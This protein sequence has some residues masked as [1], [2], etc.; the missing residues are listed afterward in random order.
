M[1]FD[2]ARVRSD[3]PLLQQS[4]RGKPLVYLDS[5]ATT[6]KPNSVILAVEQYYREQNANVHRGVYELSERATDAYEAARENVARFIHAS[7]PEE[8]VFVR[9]TTEALN[10]VASGLG[11]V[12]LEKGDTV[13]TTIAEHHSNIVPWHMLRESSGILVEFVDI[14]PAG[15]LRW[16]E[17]DRLLGEGTKVVTV[18]HVSNVLGTVHPVREIAERAHTAGAA[19][20]VDAA[21]SASHHPIDVQAMGCDFLALSGHKML[22][23]TGIGVLWGRKEWL[24]RL[25]PFL[26]GGEMIKE[27][28]T[29]RVLYRE[30]PAKFEA[31]TPN[32]AGAVGLGAALDY[33]RGLGWDGIESHEAN[34]VRHGLKRLNEAF[35]DRIRIFGPPAAADRDAIFS[36]A[37][38]GIHPHDVA[39][40]VDAEGVCVRSGHHCAQ[41]LMERLGVPALTRASC[42]VYTTPAELDQLV[43]ALEKA[44]RVFDGPGAPNS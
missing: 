38:Q 32:M 36:F 20:V 31:G 28:H 21:Q 22:G 26:G 5:A 1:A 18:A 35:G 27:V 42:H 16:D 15:R 14:D 34:L 3:F 11:R 9:G 33:L 6:Q 30:P 7:S 29:D 37:L 12:W 43:L 41:P 40:L 2:Q 24:E 4:T 25:P 19:V 17:Y 39:S 23:P 10:M 8:V 44:L 13:L